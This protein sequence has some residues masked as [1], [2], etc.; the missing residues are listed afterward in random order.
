MAINISNNQKNII[1]LFS[2]QFG[3]AFFPVVLMPYYYS[4][5]GGEEFSLIAVS[6][7]FA[8]IVLTI[9]LYGFDIYGIS[10]ILD[11]VESKSATAR[12]FFAILSA[13]LAL[14]VLAAIAVGGV[15]FLFKRPYFETFLLLLGYPLGVILQANYYYLAAQKNFIL[16]VFVGLPKIILVGWVIFFNEFNTLQSMSIAYSAGY[17][18]SGLLSVFYFVRFHR[19]RVTIRVLK[20]AAAITWRSMSNFIASLAVFPLRGLGLIVVSSLTDDND[21]ISAFALADRFVKVAQASI[22]PLAQWSS[23]SLVAG[24]KSIG[25]DWIAVRKLFFHHSRWLIIGSVVYIFSYLFAYFLLDIESYLAGNVKREVFSVAALMIPAIL[26]GSLSSVV[27][28]AV[29]ASIG[30]NILYMRLLVCNSF[31]SVFLLLLFTGL[32]SVWGSAI[33][34]ATVELMLFL[35]LYW[36]LKRELE[37]RRV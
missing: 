31:F 14:F 29:Y 1:G 3:T 10:G 9:G 19:F 8:L 18:I 16:G 24:I 13:R 2:I 30:A 33:A 21:Y 35:S 11:R 7:S 4:F 12:L 22:Y 32:F 15:V 27:S 6:E 17:I 34:A 37:C 20:F 36:F 25:L 26:F 5:L 23:V 28:G